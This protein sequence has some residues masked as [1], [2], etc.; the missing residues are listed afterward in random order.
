MDPLTITGLVLGLVQAL[1]LAFAK[2]GSSI[3]DQKV[4]DIVPHT[5]RIR[6]EKMA[7][8]AEALKKFGSQP[9]PNPFGSDELDPFDDPLSGVVIH[10]AHGEDD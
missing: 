9:P 5:L 4:E 2:Y 6:L 10:P 1:I 7:A 8:D 3:W